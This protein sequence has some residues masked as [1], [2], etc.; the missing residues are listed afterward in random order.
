M[1]VNALEINR[2]ILKKSGI[3]TNGSTVL[4]NIRKAQ[5][6]ATRPIKKAMVN[7]ILLLIFDEFKL[8]KEFL[9]IYLLEY[10]ITYYV[11]SVKDFYTFILSTFFQVFQ[12]PCCTVLFAW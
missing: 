8:I 4:P 3:E 1:H 11:Y 6:V 5:T 10:I 2:L 9:R 12:S 7:K